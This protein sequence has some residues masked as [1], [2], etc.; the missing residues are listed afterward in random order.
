MTPTQ[1]FALCSNLQSVFHHFHA[2]AV[3]IPLYSILYDPHPKFWN[4]PAIPWLEPLELLNPIDFC[5]FIDD[6]FEEFGCFFVRKWLQNAYSYRLLRFHWR[7]LRRIWLFFAKK[8]ARKCVI[9]YKMGLWLTNPLKT[10]PFFRDNFG[11]K[12]FGQNSLIV[13]TF[14]EF[15]PNHI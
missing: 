13:R 9:L 14:A 6:L 7:I 2:F 15:A 11:R 3:G 1:N 5:D 4:G 8:M 12:K 10:S